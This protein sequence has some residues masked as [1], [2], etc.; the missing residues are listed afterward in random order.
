MQ[1]RTP[2]IVWPQWKR[3]W[4]IL[5]K[6]D[7]PRKRDASGSEVGVDGKMGEHTLRGGGGGEWDKLWEEGPGRWQLNKNNLI[8]KRKNINSLF[9]KCILVIQV[10]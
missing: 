7:I 9:K 6:L 2:N 3:I 1:Q 5:W 4:L 8:N 10:L